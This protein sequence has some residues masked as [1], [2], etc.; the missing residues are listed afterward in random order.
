MTQ[1]V[2][3]S[4]V[5]MPDS[6][7]LSVY[8]KSGGY[9]ALKKVVGAVKPDDLVD[10]VKSS[11]LRG[12]GGAGFPAGVK[13]GFVP[14]D[15]PKP[16]YLACN[17]DEGEPG[18]FKDRLL[19]LKDPH[20]LIEGIIISSYAIGVNTAFIYIRGEYYQEAKVLEGA[21]R[22]AYDKG[23]LGKNIL[24]SG[25]DLELLLHRGA[26]SY[27]CGDE[28]ALMESIEG[29]RGNPRLKPPFPASVG[30]YEGPTVINNVE[31]LSA[32]PF[33]ALN[34][35]EVYTA[36][37]TEKSAG[38]KLFC[39]SGNVKKPG[40][41]E[42][43]L[44]YPLKDL[45]Y[46]IC[47]GIVD[48][49]KLKGVIPG[50]SSTPILLPSEVED[51]KLAYENASP[52]GF[53]LGSG[54]V[55]VIDDRWCMVKVAARLAKFYAHESC[56]QCTPCREGTTWTY[57]ILKRIESGGGRPEDP[58]LLLDIQDNIFGKTLCPLG[59]AAAMPIIAIVNKFRSEFEQ[60]IEEGRC[61]FK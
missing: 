54:A 38:T 14:K 19:I 2:L 25:Y 49:R 12:R 16:K 37:G 39:V 40:V 13:W 55:I 52:G 7:T 26:G 5:E 27:V 28:T 29:H 56:G 21:I 17:A 6:H 1:K 58:D 18:T 30:L 11:G 23:Y 57:K 35:A 10:I 3:L 59:D 31:T 60:H 48:G 53:M 46:N 15:S 34:G 4:R 20:Q 32:V 8:E 44:G 61:P 51:L 41:Y 36:I 24:K 22:E 33:I 45:I 9:E 47:G 50:G 43:P 42:L